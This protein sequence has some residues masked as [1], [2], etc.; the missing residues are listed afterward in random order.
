MNVR[1]RG[2]LFKRRINRGA[3]DRQ[4]DIPLVKIGE[5]ARLAGDSA[6]TQGRHR[7]ERSK[8]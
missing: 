4:V 1:F 2:W 5:L 7:H 8:G 6:K 3:I